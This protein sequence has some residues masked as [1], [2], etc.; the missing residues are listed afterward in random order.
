MLRIAEQ[1]HAS[2]LG[3]QRQGNEDNYFVRAPL[4]VVADGMGG[5]QAGEVASE[6]AVEA[7]DGGLPDGSPGEALA[8]VIRE[9]NRRIHDRSQSDEQHSG[10]GTTC[11]AAYVGENEVTVAHVGDSRA[12]LW[13]NGDLTRLTRDHSLVGELVARGKLTEEQA[14]SHPQRSVITRALGPEAEVDVDVEVF[15]AHSGDVYLLCSDGLTSMIHEPGVRPV[16]E[17]MTSLEQAGRD[18]ITAANDAGGRDNITVILFRLEDV[19][20]AGAGAADTSEST[21]Q[22]GGDDGGATTSFDTFEGEAV[23]RQ[24][25]SRPY[26]HTRARDDEAMHAGDVA[27]AV[28]AGDETEAEYRA[29]GTVALSAIKPRTETEAAPQRTVALPDGRDPKKP[30]KAKRRRRI[31]GWLIAVIAVIVLVG[32]GFWLATQ[33]VYFVGVDSSRGNEITI[34]NGLPVDLPLGIELY[35]RYQGSGVTLESVPA[36][37]RPTFT[38]HKLRSKDDA[39]NLVIQLARGQIE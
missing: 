2:D 16:L 14:E 33:A 27:H 39:E 38:D 29:T 32:S 17:R 20:G 31:P 5:A 12:Y 19:D 10:M 23:P 15:G 35:R 30:P 3:R 6:I 22:H 9:A 26:A 25:V 34:Y 13:R 37:R 4:F 18:L 28:R 24:G 21:A 8:E 7:F 11:T 36:A 1:F